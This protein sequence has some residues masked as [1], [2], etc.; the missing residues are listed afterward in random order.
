MNSRP[1]FVLLAALGASAEIAFADPANGAS[2]D[3]VIA[4]LGSPTGKLAIG[5]REELHYPRGKVVLKNGVVTDIDL[6]SEK[7]WQRRETI[8]L[9]DEK[10]KAENEARE[11][12]ALAERRRRGAEALRLLLADS[13][14]MESTGET[15]VETLERFEKSFPD[16][17]IAAVKLEAVR[18][19]DLELAE[20]RK[21]Q[22]LETR[23]ATAE[24][25]VQDA[26]NRARVA[27]N[28]ARAASE[29]AKQA[30]ASAY[31]QR[32]REQNSGLQAYTFAGGG[33]I[34]GRPYCE[35]PYSGST[36][37]IS[38][39]NIVVTGGGVPPGVRPRPIV[40]VRQ[41]PSPQPPK[42]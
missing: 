25:R 1:W 11:T 31:L 33:L 28:N 29:A 14:W 4:E 38:N 35:Y 22:A 24:A 13:R 37:A 23:V 39:G 2:R 12:A 7:E 10:T 40:I 17:D 34:N 41:Q 36:V 6:L 5:E 9:A 20:K 27:E 18:K 26:E 15:R 30:E 19:R 21:I 42:K 32:V 3:A 16:S 8:R